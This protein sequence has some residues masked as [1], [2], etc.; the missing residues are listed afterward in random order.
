VDTGSKSRR[1]TRDQ[2]ISASLSN[3]SSRSGPA[4]QLAPSTTRDIQVHDRRVSAVIGSDEPTSAQSA[5]ADAA[6]ATRPDAVIM[7]EQ[8]AGPYRTVSVVVNALAKRASGAITDRVRTVSDAVGP[9]L[10]A[11]HEGS[12]V[13]C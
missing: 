5:P 8:K 4:S 10:L 9:G 3:A 12:S 6:D 7:A 2:Q 13:V 11:G 1:G